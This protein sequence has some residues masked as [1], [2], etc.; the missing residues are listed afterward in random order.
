MRKA[1]EILLTIAGIILLNRIPSASA[2]PQS[3]TF[4]YEGEIYYGSLADYNNLHPNLCQPI[5]PLLENWRRHADLRYLE[6]LIMSAK[7]GGLNQDWDT[8]IINAKRA[9]QI[10][11][12]DPISS[13]IIL[14]ATLAK[15][16][17]KSKKTLTIDNKALS[18]Y[19]VWVILT[20]ISKES[21]KYEM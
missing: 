4:T 7:A 3:C 10:Y 1:I 15:E 21:L 5:S 11:P 12:D 18:S 6:R 8:A 9:L 17:E 14:A 20:G 19:Q 2:K 16:V 13:K